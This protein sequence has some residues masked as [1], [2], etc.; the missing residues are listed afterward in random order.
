M[1]TF[2]YGTPDDEGN[3]PDSLDLNWPEWEFNNRLSFDTRRRVHSAKT[4]GRSQT[5]FTGYDPETFRIPL[6]YRH[7][8]RQNP[9]R[10]HWHEPISSVQ[11]L[12]GQEIDVFYG[13][14]ELG[15]WKLEA[16]RVEYD[17]PALVPE[18]GGQNPAPQGAYFKETYVTL[19]LISDRSRF[20]ATTT[21]P[22]DEIDPTTGTPINVNG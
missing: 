6:I 10:R 2:R 5:N 13:R 15:T 7:Y 14:D 21:T 19:E 4:F 22:P 16:T 18:V 1:I 11:Q 17:Q 20:E 3:R 12:V 8:R 9:T